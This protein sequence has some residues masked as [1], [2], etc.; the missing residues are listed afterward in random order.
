MLYIKHRIIFSG[1][2]TECNNILPVSGLNASSFWDTN[3]PEQR[4]FWSSTN[5]DSGHDF[6]PWA[7]D[8]NDLNPWVEVELNDKSTITGKT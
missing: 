7:A 3:S 4:M 8:S 6:L 1:P 2:L 5:M